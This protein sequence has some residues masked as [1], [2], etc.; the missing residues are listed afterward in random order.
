MNGEKV[1]QYVS[2]AFDLPSEQRDAYVRKVCGEDQ[3]LLLEV[4]SLLDAASH[5]ED[6][7]F[8]P[9][10]ARGAGDFPTAAKREAQPS[11]LS[12]KFPDIDA[13][14]RFGR[15]KV[16]ERIGDGGMGIVYRAEQRT[17]MR[18][19]VVVKVIKLG[20][21]TKLVIARFEAER[22][23]LAMM[24]HPHIAK[25]YDAGS[26]DRG[27]PYFVMEYVKGTPILDYCDRNHLTVRQRLE[28]FTQ[29]C[30]A[31]QH[32][33]HK[34]I[35]HRDIKPSNILVSTQDGRAFAKVIDFG[36]AKATN[37]R[38]T[39]RTLFTEHVNM[40]GTPA[41]M[42]PEQAD[43]NIDIDTRTDVYSLG[44]VLYELLTGH[45]PFDA[46]RLKSAAINEIA[47]IIREEEP[48]RPSTLV[49]TMDARPGGS[50]LPKKKVGDSSAG[51]AATLATLAKARGSSAEAYEK[52]LRG[53]VDWIVMKALEKDRARRY[54]TPNEL[55]EDVERHLNGLPILAAPPSLLYQARK[56]ARK[57]RAPVAAGLAIALVL[58]IAIA[59]VSGLA[60]QLSHQV[61]VARAALADAQAARDQ[62]SVQRQEAE[63]QRG[64][65][66]SAAHSAKYEAAR[67]Q[68]QYLISQRLLD[69]ALVA[70]K[71]AYN[72]GGNW[73]DGL[74]LSQIVNESR[75]TWRLEH[76]IP[77][78]EAPI[79]GAISQTSGGTMMVV[80]YPSSLVEYDLDSGKLVAQTKATAAITGLVP[81]QGTGDRIA[82]ITN[83]SVQMLSLND[84]TMA[85]QH[86][87]GSLE[88]IAA[89]ASASSEIAL[90]LSD[91]ATQV[92]SS[93]LTLLASQPWPANAKLNQNQPL[94][95]LAI[96]PNG[97]WVVSS[98]VTWWDDCLIWNLSTGRTFLAPLQAQSIH[99][100]G[101]TDLVGVQNS[102]EV[103]LGLLRLTIDPDH[104]TVNHTWLCSLAGNDIGSFPQLV[105]DSRGIYLAGTWGYGQ[106]T[107]GRLSSRIPG[108]V[109]QRYS[110]LLGRSDLSPSPLAMAADGSQFALACNDRLMIF[111]QAHAPETD[112]SEGHHAALAATAFYEAEPDETSLYLRI[113]PTNADRPS[114]RRRLTL[115]PAADPDW[116]SIACGM[117]VS[118]DQRTL[119]VRYT[120]AQA[121][122]YMTVGKKTVNHMVVVYSG[123]DPLT[124]RPGN[125]PP[126]QIRLITQDDNADNAAR[127]YH[128]ERILQLSPDGKYLLVG[129]RVT[130][131]SSLG[132]L[133]RT[134]DGQLLHYWSAGQ[135][136][137]L[138][139]SLGN[140]EYFAD[141]SLAGNSIRLISW[142]T[143]NVAR[144]IPLPGRL[145]GLCGAAGG[146]EL[147]AS[148]DGKS[149]GR[150]SV[151]TGQLLG[152]IDSNL[153]PVC[154]APDGRVFIGYLPEADATGS[155]SM[156]LA[157]GQ[158]GSVMA[159][160]S[161]GTRQNT[162]AQFAADGQSFM[163]Q[164]S[165]TSTDLVRNLSPQ[166]AD[167]ILDAGGN[168][169]AN[170]TPDDTAI[171][172]PPIKVFPSLAP[173]SAAGPLETIDATD[174]A[175]LT[176][177]I[178]TK[179]TVVGVTASTT[180]TVGRTAL[181]INFGEPG[182]SFTVFVRPMVYGQL[183]AR[184]GGLAADALKQ[185]LVRVT[186][187]I[188]VYHGLPE[189]LLDSPAHLQIVDAGPATAP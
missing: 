37:Q 186:G 153:T 12:M 154:C 53:E 163:L 78:T 188:V 41:Y 56:F 132:E 88:V 184:F 29:V 122:D 121:P 181:V 118:Q 2:E 96:S 24:D 31:I 18:R 92:Y 60:L 123:L 108:V 174:M 127:E 134:S 82:A 4:L 156:L 70:A 161:R 48:L 169:T 104:S 99:F 164:S 182:K 149:I 23:A 115:L 49:N 6:D 10:S 157:D 94:A 40:I 5:A 71:E 144:E 146:D 39:D 126:V 13:P 75:N 168:A 85:A 65:A 111:G 141:A 113:T 66:E 8:L 136:S 26:D 67:N 95:K 57:H 77:V 80:A 30:Q 158:T 137:G 90:T 76:S 58:V 25:V 117:A 151:K 55:A 145:T 34:G 102:F 20:M 189:M 38:L 33:H 91:R 52:S 155:G 162:A 116:A 46:R 35:I 47:R 152:T 179:A 160:L 135:L 120:Q 45:T 64:S 72:L 124:G 131:E 148:I 84:L 170:L 133:Y 19:E 110:S 143:G 87:F 178:G 180:L 176:A 21:D 119:A 51:S 44:V 93:D 61:S 7:G 43:G 36:I 89:E 105:A 50:G 138:V 107:F 17:P 16:L 112:W 177:D 28:L 14:E 140:S 142:E 172:P 125:T 54:A 173:P 98:G 42:S 183:N 69:Q 103:G 150:Y 171:E 81:F 1:K 128:D 101:D 15:Y 129:T 159:V 187:T 27:R 73:Q 79:C 167:R 106:V 32:A 3:S 165:L 175:K 100:I 62:E 114:V 166:D 185:K 63:R 22:Q 86:D 97:Q 74:L 68:A 59:S 109:T 130:F 83:N 139:T 11:T 147:L 9:S